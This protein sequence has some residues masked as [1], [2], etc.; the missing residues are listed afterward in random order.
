VLTNECAS[1]LDELLL[2]YI[3]LNTFNNKDG[4]IFI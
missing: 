1:I 4:A 3:F 2:G